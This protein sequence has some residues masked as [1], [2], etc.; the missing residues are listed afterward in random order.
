MKVFVAGAT[1]AMGKQLVPRLIAAGH[2]VVGT[3]RSEAK[4]GALWDLGATPVVVDALDPDQVARGRRERATR[5]DRPRADLDRGARHA[6]FRPHLRDDQPAED[7]G[8]GSP[9]V[10][11]PRGRRQAVRR[12][13]LYGLAVRADR[14]PG[15]DRGRSAR[16][17]SGQRDAR[18]DGGDPPPRDGGHGS[19]LDRGDRAPVRGVLWSRDVPGPGRRTVRDGAQAQVPRWSATAAACGRSCTSRTPPRRPSRPSSAASAG[20]TTSCD[21]DPAAVAEWLPALAQTI[22]AP[23]PWH[24]PRLVGRLVAGEAAVVM[25]TEIRGASNAKA[26]RELGWHPEHPSWREGFAA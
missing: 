6:P 12:P 1:G 25:M 19:R 18:I 26:K 10:R 8:H 17:D 22:G 2:A 13:E 15:Q 24:V 7:R 20:S 14:R 16:P 9:A 23:K 3:T 5:C 4:Q 21:D 11:G